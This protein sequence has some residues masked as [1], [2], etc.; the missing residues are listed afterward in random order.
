MTLEAAMY[1]A[2][3]EARILEYLSQVQITSP[4]QLQ[5]VTG[6]SLA[7]V[8]RDLN[9]LEERGLVRRSHGYVQLCAA[10]PRPSLPS[11]MEEKERIATAAAAEIHDGDIIFLGSGTTCT[12]LAR[13]LQGK[14]NLTI[15]TIN[16]DV[17]H[18]LTRLEGVKLSL[19]GGEVRV[20]ADYMETLDEY[21]MQLLK[22]LYF[23]KV[24]VTVNGIDF[25]FG[26]S[27]RM[28][29][30]LTLFQH[31][32]RNSKVFYCLADASKFNKR[33]YVQFCPIDAIPKLVTTREVH[34]AYAD[35]FAQNGIEVICG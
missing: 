12:C 18:E 4:A 20:E 11:H 14:K 17:M 9:N 23:D 21:T 22:R 30:Q 27:I 28:Q 16:L 3:R 7:T 5:P 2:E 25:E 35:R 24:F 13:H 8:R 33:T 6:A 19:L 29:L 31:L 34:A 32:L 26:Y 1:Q 15:M 10:A